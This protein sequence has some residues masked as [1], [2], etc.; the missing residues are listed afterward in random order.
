M[1]QDDIETPEISYGTSIPYFIAD[2]SGQRRSPRR[3]ERFPIYVLDVTLPA[4]EVDLAYDPKKRILGYRV[5]LSE[6]GR[7]LMHRISIM[8]NHSFLL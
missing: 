7:E 6:K 1:T 2:G 4:E 8:S 3:L 5:S